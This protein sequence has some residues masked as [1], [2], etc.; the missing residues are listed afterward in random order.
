M[1]LN[2]VNYIH[3]LEHPNIVKY[4]DLIESENNS[5]IFME[6][7]EGGTLESLIKKQKMIPEYYA[8]SYFR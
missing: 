6:Y 5:Y 7:C 3:I 4:I 1:F 2:S 8:L